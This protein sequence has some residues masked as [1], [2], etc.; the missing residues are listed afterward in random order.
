MGDGGGGG[1]S[2]GID[3]D[4]PT[5][6]FNDLF[7]RIANG[8]TNKNDVDGDDRGGGGGG[9]DGDNDDNDQD[10]ENEEDNED[11]DEEEEEEEDEEDVIAIFAE[12]AHLIIKKEYLNPEHDELSF[13]ILQCITALNLTVDVE[14]ESRASSTATWAL[15]MI[16]RCLVTQARA[17]GI[18]PKGEED[19]M[20]VDLLKQLILRLMA[21]IKM[22]PG[23]EG[24]T[25]YLHANLALSIAEYA[26]LHTT[27]FV[28]AV[29]KLPYA[30]KFMMEWF[31]C[32]RHVVPGGM[33]VSVR[34]ACK[35]IQAILN[36]M[37]PMKNAVTKEIF[38]ACFIAL[39]CC[40]Y[41]HRYQMELPL[42]PVV[43]K[44]P[45]PEGAAYYAKA[46]INR[47]ALHRSVADLAVLIP[48]ELKEH[49]ASTVDLLYE[50]NPDMFTATLND[51]DYTTEEVRDRIMQLREQ[52]WR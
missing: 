46:A 2:E 51:R 37:R 38:C 19:V 11:E 16:E 28:Q 4:K 49:L 6:S 7:K 47:D 1:G 27:Q 50:I 15:G 31:S 29:I 25:T 17:T 9:H 26:D 3:I 30:T 23:E 40:P 24:E 43:P 8:G 20:I 41:L 5:G 35:A 48:K 21:N 45:Q 52:A 14:L 39:S 22:P 12:K 44:L 13:K 36:I 34:G 42:F 32:L 18:L 33:I 10:G